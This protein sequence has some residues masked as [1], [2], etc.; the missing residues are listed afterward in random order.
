MLG[1]QL[2]VLGALLMVVPTIIGTLFIKTQKNLL[3]VWCSGQITLWAGF[4]FIC[5]PL[6]LWKKSF[7]MACHIYNGYTFLL[8]LLAF[9][10]L[11]R[12]YCLYKRS[13]LNHGIIRNKVTG[14]QKILWGIFGC[15]LVLQLWMTVFWAYEEGDDAFYLATATITEASDTM[16]VR[17]PYTG[18]TTGLDARHGLAPFPVWIAYLSRM[19]GMH[20]ITVGQIILPLVIVGMAYG[21]YGLLAAHLCKEKKE[22]LAFFMIVIELLFMFGGYSLYNAENF[23]L[24]RA[25]QGKAVVANIVIPFLLYLYLKI[26]SDLQE[27]KR[28]SIGG[29]ILVALTAIAGCLCSTQ[30]TILVC[31]MMGV[32]GVCATFVYKNVKVF[33]QTGLCCM[34]PGIL[35]V[36]YLCIH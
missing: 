16:Y 27:N 28:S 4:L 12:K 6:I 31:M 2:L 24:V 8:V 30:G 13:N 5:V 35:A 23:L 10:L 36:L 7:T 17:L 32:T 9:V 26:F 11:G 33:L 18:A 34:V 15:L 3:F 22:S 19:S 21:I 14:K 25:S 1:I 20:P 29:W